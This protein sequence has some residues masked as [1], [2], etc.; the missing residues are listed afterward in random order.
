M[1]TTL[2]FKHQDSQVNSNFQNDFHPTSSC[3]FLTYK[4]NTI[5]YCIDYTSCGCNLQS[6]QWHS[7]NAGIYEHHERPSTT[8]AQSHQFYHMKHLDD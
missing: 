8:K 3:A 7:H 2:P 5:P 4:S 1:E 6:S